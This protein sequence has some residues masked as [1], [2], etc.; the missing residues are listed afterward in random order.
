MK[1]EMELTIPQQRV[2]MVAAIQHALHCGY[3][4]RLQMDLGL[5][6]IQ[7]LI[8]VFGGAIT[9]S[10][11][12]KEPDFWMT[13]SLTNG[14]SRFVVHLEMTALAYSLQEGAFSGKRIVFDGPTNLA[15]LDQSYFVV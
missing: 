5:E 8:S 3:K 4:S 1:N 2:S 12:S 9:L 7:Y 15:I 13:Y 6:D 10:D 14:K 11:P